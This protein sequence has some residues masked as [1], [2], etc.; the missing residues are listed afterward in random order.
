LPLQGV[1]TCGPA[2]TYALSASTRI[3]AAAS[4][5]TRPQMRVALRSWTEPG[6]GPDAHT[7]VP[8]GEAITCRFM[9]CFL[10]LIPLCSS[11]RCGAW[12]YDG[13]SDDLEEGPGQVAFE[14]A[15]DLS[16][17]TS[18]SGAASDVV[19]RW[20]VSSQA[21]QDRSEQCGVGLTIPRLMRRRWFFPEDASTVLTPHSAAKDAPLARR[22]G[23]S[24]AV[25]SRVAV[26][27]GPTPNSAS[28][29]G[30]VT[31]TA[32]AMRLSRSLISCVRCWIRRARSRSVCAGCRRPS[33][34]L[35]VQR[36][37]SRYQRGGAQPRGARSS[38]S[39]LT[40]SILS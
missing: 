12:G 38:G 13:G 27:S 6:S 4:T 19:A 16:F 30:A 2:P 26:E 21:Y 5:R 11:R 22:S 24:P 37:A 8:L 25:M 31:S 39:A 35:R 18:F 7:M 32:E 17:R 33:V 36:G 23:L 1:L 20:S 28:N 40:R 29:F 34:V 14:T 10:C 3:P 15:D 9:P